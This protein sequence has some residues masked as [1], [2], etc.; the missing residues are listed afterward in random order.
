[1]H[2]FG[3]IGAI[4]FTGNDKYSLRT[5][6]FSVFA[7]NDPEVNSVRMGRKTHKCCVSYQLIDGHC[8]PSDTVLYYI[9]LK[10]T[11]FVGG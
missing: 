3:Q 9:P 6:N 7:A 4:F 5:F 10:F 1:M 11:L 8:W 2:V